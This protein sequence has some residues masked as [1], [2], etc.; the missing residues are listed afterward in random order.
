MLIAFCIAVFM[1]LYL[2][3]H[4]Y[5]S[6]FS[7][8]FMIPVLFIIVLGLL[9][10]FF[11]LRLINNY[12]PYSLFRVIQF[13]FYFLLG[14]VAYAIIFYIIADILRLFMN[15]NPKIE[16]IIIIIAA[17]FV[18]VLGYINTRVIREVNYVVYSEKISKPLKVILV[19]DIHIGSPDVTLSKFKQMI[20][21]I[22][23]QN[24]DFV[25]M[26]GDIIDD[27]SIEYQELGYGSLFAEIKS[28]HGV[29]ATIGNHET[30]QG[31]VDCVEE[32]F[33]SDGLKVL[34]NS[35]EFFEDYNLNLIGITDIGRS[36]KKLQTVDEFNLEENIFNLLIEH[37]PI[38]F[39][40]NY[41]YNIDLQVSGHTHAGQ[42]IHG[43]IITQIMYTKPWGKLDINSSS[44]ITSTGVG[45][46][47]PPMRDI[48]YPEIVIINIEPKNK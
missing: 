37:N 23:A 40:N 12:I 4:I 21:K 29:Y 41:K 9:F 6:F 3:F 46:W 11:W 38:R 22:N 36:N 32:K 30:Y 5:Y 35:Q 1:T 19:S 15:I 42:I 31:D 8:K 33:I 26:A 27:A 47:G 28:K 10:S 45:S 20:N 44:L 43:Y 2:S 7:N 14:M 25:I 39:D 16:G 17:L 13:I 34:N 48:T 24:A 18:A